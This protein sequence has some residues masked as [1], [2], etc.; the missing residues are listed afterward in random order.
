MLDKN[1]IKIIKEIIDESLDVKVKKI[2]DESLDVRLKEMD[3]SWDTR[4]KEMDKSWDTK[5]KGMD[6]SWDTRL[7]EMDRSWDT[8]LDAKLTPIMEEIVSIKGEV[9]N[10]KEDVANLKKEMI[11]MERRIDIKLGDM[12]NHLKSMIF[13]A[14]D[15]L[16]DLIEKVKQANS[17]DIMAVNDDVQEVK[18][19]ISELEINFKAMQA[20]MV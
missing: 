6:E 4:L 2:I 17:E 19:R 8:R 20:K 5:L 9:Y 18:K 1:D 13:A 14:Q 10:L 3:E 15:D 12:F 7:K 16:K 11:E